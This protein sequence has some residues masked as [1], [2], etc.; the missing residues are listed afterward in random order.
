MHTFSIWKS[1][2]P[3]MCTSRSAFRPRPRTT[4]PTTNSLLSNRASSTTMYGRSSRQWTPLGMDVHSERTRLGASWAEAG[5]WIL[6]VVGKKCDMKLRRDFLTSGLRLAG[7]MVSR[8]WTTVWAVEMPW[9]STARMMPSPKE[10]T[11]WVADSTNSTKS[12]TLHPSST[13]SMSRLSTSHW[14]FCLNRS[15]LQACK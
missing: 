15:T 12:A 2:N 5:S 7:S 6:A 10:S 4:P 11:S 9:A 14:I 13:A 1:P 3:W 8:C